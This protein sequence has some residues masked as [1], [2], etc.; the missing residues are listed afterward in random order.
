MFNKSQNN[1]RMPCAIRG[2]RK[3]MHDRGALDKEEIKWRMGRF[4][5]DPTAM[6]ERGRTSR[7]AKRGSNRDRFLVLLIYC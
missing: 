7:D 6:L 1:P 2:K 3:D 4:G 5:V